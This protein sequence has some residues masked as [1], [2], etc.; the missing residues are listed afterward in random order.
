MRKC[1]KCVSCG[2][3]IGEHAFSD[4]HLC[5]YCERITFVS[6]YGHFYDSLY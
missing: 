2:K 4:V 3:V 5:R 6:R 1:D